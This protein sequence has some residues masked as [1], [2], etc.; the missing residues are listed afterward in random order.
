MA[1]SNVIFLFA[2]LPLTLGIY[3]LSKNEYKNIILLVASL[4]FYAYGEPQMV[5]LMIASIVC[6]YFFALGIERYRCKNQILVVSILYNLG[7]LFVFK[8]LD[9][10]VDIFN[11]VSGKCLQVPEIIMPI[12]ISFY[13]FQALSYVIDVYNGRTE[14]QHNILNLGLYVSLFSAVGSWTD[15]EI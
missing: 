10:T 15:C 7:M 3:Y 13:T 12:G 6:N 5:L 2:F 4:F 14:A 9:F 11:L 1:F 8:Y